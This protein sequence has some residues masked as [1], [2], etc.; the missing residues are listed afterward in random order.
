M[1]NRWVIT[2]D[3][4]YYVMKAERI[5]RGKGIRIDLIPTPRE[6]S[7]DCGVAIRLLDERLGLVKELFRESVLEQA[8]FFEERSK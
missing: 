1:S 6:I 2:F 8:T 4:V 3:S 5:L 7:S